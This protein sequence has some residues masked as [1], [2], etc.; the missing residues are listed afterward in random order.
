MDLYGRTCYLVVVNLSLNASLFKAVGI[1][2]MQTPPEATAG[3]QYR[4]FAKRI[5]GR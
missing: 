2:S 1:A 3:E 5:T 4:S